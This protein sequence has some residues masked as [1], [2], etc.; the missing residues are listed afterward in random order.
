MSYYPVFLEMK[1]RRC[2]VIGGGLVA[3]R[4]VATLVEAGARV[5]VIAPELTTN[6]AAWSQRESI[7]AIT[8]AYRPGD[9]AGYEMVFVATDVPQ[10]NA[11]VYEEGKSRGI[12]VNAADDPAHCDFILPSVLRRGAL[13]VAV[14]TGATSP[15]LAR[16]V[17]EE[18]E[19]YFSRDYE[20]VAELAAE[21][22]E[23]LRAR[24]I[25]PGYEKWRQALTGEL[26]QWVKRGERRQAKDFLLKELGAIPC[27]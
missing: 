27:K 11:A 26:R 18:L 1:E 20:V 6:L 17:R 4:K 13:T 2:L 21:V 5:T 16:M 25:A 23:E 24:G 10:V 12:W 14:S 9:L 8:R 7:H 15:A 22:R 3:E 19:G